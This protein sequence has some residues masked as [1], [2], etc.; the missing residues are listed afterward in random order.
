VLLA[1]LASQPMLLRVWVRCAAVRIAET[2]VLTM[3]PQRVRVAAESL[4]RALELRDIAQVVGRKPRSVQREVVDVRYATTDEN[5]AARRIVGSPIAPRVVWAIIDPELAECLAQQHV[6]AVPRVDAGQPVSYGPR[7]HTPVRAARLL[8]SGS[9]AQDERQACD[10]DH[11]ADH[12]IPP[13]AD[14]ATS[15]VSTA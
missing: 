4:A 11:S 15:G 8:R 7:V 5:D 9:A 13:A 3:R 14:R 6:A 12:G 2:G 10:S 1:E